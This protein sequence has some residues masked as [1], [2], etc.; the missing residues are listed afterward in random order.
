MSTTH[1]ET[2]VDAVVAALRH[3]EVE[4]PV[5]VADATPHS[6]AELL[7]RRFAARGR[8]LRIVSVPGPVIEGVA[9]AIESVWRLAQTR[10]EPPLTRY[11]VTQLTAPIVLDLGRFH[12]EL[13][14]RPDADVAQRAL[15]LAGA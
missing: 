11:A 9:A 10:R 13:G 1:V 4:G 6:A 7:R 5:N 14:I 8:E 3:P 15:E 12:H 2:L